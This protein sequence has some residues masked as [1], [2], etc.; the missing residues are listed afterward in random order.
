MKSS[1]PYQS[2]LQA[3]D[4]LPAPA[5]VPITPGGYFAAIMVVIAAALV[6]AA[7]IPGRTQGLAL[8]TNRLLAD[9]PQLTQNDFSWINFWATIIGGFFCWPCG[10][11]LDRVSPKYIV[12]LTMAALAATTIGMATA[13]T[14]TALFVYI[15]L[16]RGL[17][18]SM[19]SVISIT[20]MAKWFRRD[21]SVAMGGYAVVMTMMMAVGFGILQGIVVKEGW[22]PMWTTLGWALLVMAPVAG[23]FSWPV[24]AGRKS[25]DVATVPFASATLRTSL[26]TSCFWVF[27]L[28]IS[29]FG[30]VSSGV[31]LYQVSIFESIG[32]NEKVFH[33]CQLIGLAVGLLSNFVTGWLAR[34]FS[35][36]MLLGLAMTIFA[37]SLV[38]LP[39]LR[40][41]EQAYAQAVV[42]AFAGGAITV[43]FFMIWVHA[44]GP[45]YVGEITGTVQWMTVIAS[46]IGP[47]CV[48]I[49]RDLFGGYPGIIWLLGV[50]A[51]ALAVASFL[52]KVPVAK[53]G[54]WT[55][56]DPLAGNPSNYHLSQE[57]T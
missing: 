46:A 23:I 5:V 37:G 22:R 19:L 33:V 18:Q 56:L 57:T 21:L 20:L 15:T 53:R 47:P 30:L 54:D 12:V 48:T 17:G 26:G 24:T 14:S 35:L 28:S 42:H 3:A 55:S 38:T 29:L 51:A 6:M 9:F 39:L 43:L 50:V 1:N 52:A 13:T 41:P 8:I 34:K 10:W 31:S 44:Y 32:L 2:P 36:S 49:G 40:T 25:V 4:I 45:K 16:T 7:T 27:S 11:L